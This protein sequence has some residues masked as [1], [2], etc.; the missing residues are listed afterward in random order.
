[1]PVIGISPC[2]GPLARVVP[3]AAGN[4][5]GR[6]SGSMAR[7]TPRKP[8]S[9]SSQSSVSRFISMVR[10]ALVTSV[11][12]TPPSVPPVRFHSTHESVVPKMA[13]PFSASARRPSTLSSS[14]LILP[15]AKYVAGGSPALCR[16]TSPA[17]DRSSSLAIRSVR[18]SCQT[19]ALWYGRPVCLFQISVVSRWLVMPKLSRSEADRFLLFSAVWMTDEVRSQI[20]TGSCSTQPDWGRIWL[21]SSW[22]RPISLPP[23]S[24]I[25]HRVLVV[26][27]STAA[28]KSAIA[29]LLLESLS[30]VSIAGRRLR[31]GGALV[32]GHAGLF[33]RALDVFGQL[34]PGVQ[35]VT[36]EEVVDEH[37]DDAADQRPDDGYPEIVAEIEAAGMI[38]PW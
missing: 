25:M 16:M 24:K 2:T 29:G 8:S 7:G 4:E 17:P 15:P 38:G 34:Q 33:D 35:H 19:I 10:L 18:V 5:L 28:T 6:I 23:W 9:S 32:G 30:L 1:M 31:A 11:M 26:P 12:C 14:H 27:W 3:Y 22:W 20:S 36:D 37:A 21:C 13:S